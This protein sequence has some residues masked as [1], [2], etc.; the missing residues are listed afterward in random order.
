MVTHQ[1][2]VWCRPVKVRRSETDVLP[3]SCTAKKIKFATT[4]YF[5][6]LQ[7]EEET[8]QPNDDDQQQPPDAISTSNVTL[9][10]NADDK[11]SETQQVDDD[12]QETKGDEELDQ[13]S[14]VDQQQE[15]NDAGTGSCLSTDNSVQLRKLTE[16]LNMQ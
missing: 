2:Q 13:P 11:N 4:C 9:A 16:L 12:V 10:D 3:L 1:L 15:D 7:A 14:D 8:E 5:I 6:V